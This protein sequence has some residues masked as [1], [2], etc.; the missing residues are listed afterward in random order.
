[1]NI[2]K[3]TDTVGNGRPEMGK[4]LPDS[5]DSHPMEGIRYN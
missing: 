5:W 3:Q 2:E 1:M 4:K